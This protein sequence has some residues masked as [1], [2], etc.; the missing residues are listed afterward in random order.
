MT[1][2][3]QNACLTQSNHKKIGLCDDTCIQGQPEN[4][5]YIDENN[6]CNWI[7]AIDN[8]H[9]DL[10]KFYTIDHCV[11][12]PPSQTGEV[13]KRCDGVLVCNNII[14]FVELKSRNE[15]GAN[16]VKDAEKQLIA[17]IVKFKE[18][19]SNEIFKEKRAYIVNNRRPKSKTS[20]AIRMENFF[21]K[22]NHI[23]FIK[24]RIALY[25]LDG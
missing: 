18:S 22:T 16:W 11:E 9:K 21:A 20:Q 25:S 12:F 17:T 13:S 15:M 3:F 7:A 5:A 4:A 23:L 2:F 1:D 10:I 6:G 24:A 19:G 14:A 8:Y